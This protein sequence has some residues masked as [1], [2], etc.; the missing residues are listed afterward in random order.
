MHSPLSV[1]K[2]IFARLVKKEVR[3]VV[4]I[5]L[6]Y[7]R[8]K[9]IVKISK[10]YYEQR[11]DKLP[12]IVLSKYFRNIRKKRAKVLEDVGSRCEEKKAVS[13]SFSHKNH[14]EDNPRR[15]ICLSP[16]IQ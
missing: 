5:E 6:V 3:I 10:S 13:M 11:N 8:A 7:N 1:Q 14:M 9:S 2:I 16:Y 12:S 15:S 4:R